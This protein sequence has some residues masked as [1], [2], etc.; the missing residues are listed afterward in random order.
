MGNK[1]KVIAAVTA[2]LMVNAACKYY[3]KKKRRFPL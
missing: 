2:A 1:C 3:E